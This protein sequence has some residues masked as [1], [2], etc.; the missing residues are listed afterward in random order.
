LAPVSAFDIISSRAE[1]ILIGILCTAGVGMIASPE[2]VGDRVNV[3]TFY[4][5][6]IGTALE[7]RF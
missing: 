5:R 7:V 1:N 6:D 2:L 3:I 4:Q